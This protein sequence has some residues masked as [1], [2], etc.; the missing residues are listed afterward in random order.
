MTDLMPLAERHGLSVIE[1]CSQA[2]DA[3]VDDQR[4]KIAKKISDIARENRVLLMEIVADLREEGSE[5]DD[6]LIMLLFGNIDEMQ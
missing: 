3:V 6:D 4:R 5:A 2:Y 1:D